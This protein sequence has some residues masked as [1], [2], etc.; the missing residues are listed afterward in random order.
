MPEKENDPDIAYGASVDVGHVVVSVTGE[1]LLSTGI[2]VNALTAL[3]AYPAMQE[4]ADDP[5]SECELTGHD[6]HEVELP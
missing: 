4:Q 3:P 5:A 2:G 6:V 1:G